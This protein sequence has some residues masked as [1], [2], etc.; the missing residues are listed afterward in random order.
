[1]ESVTGGLFVE[2]PDEIAEIYLRKA[3]LDLRRGS[4][5]EAV[6]S[7]REAFRQAIESARSE[8]DDSTPLSSILHRTKAEEYAVGA[9]AKSGIDTIGDLVILT[10]FEITENL[11]ADSRVLVTVMDR[12]AVLMGDEW[13]NTKTLFQR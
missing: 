12:L 1:M 6:K 11:G 7:I 8:I 3:S 9:M 10:A 13:C 5:I 2:V 4:E